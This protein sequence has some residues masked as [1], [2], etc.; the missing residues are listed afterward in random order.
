MVRALVY[1]QEVAIKRIV[2]NDESDEERMAKN[3]FHELKI[4]VTL[5]HRNIVECIGGYW[6]PLQEGDF[7]NVSFGQ[8]E[9]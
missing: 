3:L 4:C 9:V 2:A 5:E 6:P 7:S 8:A 1:G